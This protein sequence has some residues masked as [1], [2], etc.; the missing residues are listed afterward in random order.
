MRSCVLRVDAHPEANDEFDDA[1]AHHSRRPGYWRK[2]LRK[3]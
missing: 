2:R 3:R 1:I